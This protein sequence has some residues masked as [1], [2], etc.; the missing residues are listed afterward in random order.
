MKII[1][2]IVGIIFVVMLVTFIFLCTRM[3]DFGES[4][5]YLTEEEYNETCKAYNEYYKERSRLEGKI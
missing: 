5:M 2:I 4:S 1:F 3:S